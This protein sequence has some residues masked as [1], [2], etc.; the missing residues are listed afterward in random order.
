MSQQTLT[1]VESVVREA[2]DAME[3]LD[4]ARV[5][6]MIVPDIQAVDA[7]MRTWKR[8]LDEIGAHLAALESG[9]SDEHSEI[10]DLEIREYGA[11]AIATYT[12]EQEYTFAG[13]R[14]H[15]V[16]PTTMVLSRV[17][18]DWKIALFHSLPLRDER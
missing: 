4:V 13:K 9:M 18:G 16:C 10:T 12:V 6:T 2:Y 8:G 17:D 15:D 14:H 7:V 5:A 11:T 3:K 1:D